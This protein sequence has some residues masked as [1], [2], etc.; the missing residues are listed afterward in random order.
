MADSLKSRVITW[1]TVIPS[2]ARNLVLVRFGIE[3]KDQSEIPSLRSGQAL[4]GVYPERQCEIL[5]YAQN[6]KLRA[7]DDSEG[8][9]ITGHCE[10]SEE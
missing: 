1:P 3:G 9:G 2:E 4:R 7:Q 8:L 5:R 10:I 6:E